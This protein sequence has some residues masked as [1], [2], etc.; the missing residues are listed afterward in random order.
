MMVS[1]GVL[2]SY[3]KDHVYHKQFL[4]VD[5]YQILIPYVQCSLLKDIRVAALFTF[6]YLTEYLD[7]ELIQFLSMSKT[8]LEGVVA[9]LQEISQGADGVSFSQLKFHCDEFLEATANIASHRGN[10]LMLLELNVIQ[11]IALSHIDS[12][13][14][15]LF[16]LLLW[17]LSFVAACSSHREKLDTIK[18][19]VSSI[20]PKT[21]EECHL[22]RTLELET[23][24]DTPHAKY[25]TG[26]FSDAYSSLCTCD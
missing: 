13:I 9:G 12:N 7:E 14:R 24:T 3:A 10:A 6:S 25:S 5:Y 15:V 19:F 8:E 17:K 18:D 22:K 2:H 4:D 23:L 11:A 1:L 26:E 16:L 21:R 20:T